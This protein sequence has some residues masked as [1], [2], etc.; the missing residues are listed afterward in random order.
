M[1]DA[2]QIAR[3]LIRCK[4]VT[5]DEGGALAYLE[6]FLSARGFVC[7]RL[8]FSAPGTP[9]VENLYARWGKD[10]PH[11][12]FAGHTD[13]VPVGDEA[14]WSFDPFGGEVRDGFLCGRGASDMKGAIAAFAAAAADFIAKHPPQGSISFLITGDEEGPAVNGTRKALEWM[15]EKGEKIDFCLVGEP[16]SVKHVGDTVKIGR[17][18]S[19]T[20]HLTVRGMQGHV[21]YPQLADNP[22]PRLATLLKVL[23]DLVLDTGTAHFQPSNLEIVRVET[24]PGA[25]N[26]I[27]AWARAT[28]NV[29]FNDTY[30]GES[31]ENKLREA[32]NAAGVAYALS[33]EVAG[34]SFYTPPGRYSSM[35]AGAVQA[36]T[37]RE[38]DLST[39]GGTSDARFIRAH[40]P[41]VE[42]GV[43]NQTAHKVDERVPAAD[44]TALSAIYGHVLAAFFR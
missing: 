34:E 15:K 41:V 29:R 40:C 8:K 13:V 10:A 20:G 44:I 43:T 17:R 9:D 19:L 4:S 22:V 6:G 7:H 23:S 25:E 28:F 38:P 36:V 16:T 3:E 27:P 26:V 12:C 14:A 11:F 5:P 32:L 21:A 33:V 2:V 39:S 31:L 24:S 30:T 37:G 18:G 42:L 35:V 1:T